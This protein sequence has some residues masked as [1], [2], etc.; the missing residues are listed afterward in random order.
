MLILTDGADNDSHNALFAGLDLVSR[1]QLVASQAASQ[2][3][4][5]C[6]VGVGNTVNTDA[7]ASMANGCGYYPVASFDQVASKF[8]E[9]FGFVHDFY[10]ITFPSASLGGS[11]EATIQVPGSGEVPSGEFK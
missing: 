7:M 3:V 6:V 10:R 5:V 2:K 9:I 1:A 4:N 8:Q 11:Q